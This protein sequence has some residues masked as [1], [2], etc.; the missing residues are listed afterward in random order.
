M[1][2]NL[3]QTNPNVTKSVKGG[4]AKKANN[5]GVLENT[6]IKQTLE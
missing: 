6:L 2:Q 4:S 3:D 1:I 5:L